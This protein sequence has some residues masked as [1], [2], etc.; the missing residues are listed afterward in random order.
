MISLKNLERYNPAYPLEEDPVTRNVYF[1]EH[2]NF[3]KLFLCGAFH[4]KTFAT[5]ISNTTRQCVEIRP[6]GE[7][8][9]VNIECA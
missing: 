1:N 9:E 7:S 6:A 5:I 8:R 4:V 2:V 3:V